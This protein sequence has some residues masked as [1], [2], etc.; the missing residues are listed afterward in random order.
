MVWTD[1]PVEFSSFLQ[2]KSKNTR[3]FVQLSP[4]NSSIFFCIFWWICPWRKIS[5]EYEIWNVEISRTFFY[6][7]W[8]MKW[9]SK[10]REFFSLF[11]KILFFQHFWFFAIFGNLRMS[12]FEKNKNYLWQRHGPGWLFEM[13]LYEKWRFHNFLFFF[14]VSFYSYS[15]Y[16]H[17]LR[18][19]SFKS[20]RFT[21]FMRPPTLCPKSG[22]LYPYSVPPKVSRIVLVTFAK[23]FLFC[24]V[25]LNSSLWCLAKV[26]RSM[27]LTF[28]ETL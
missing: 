13:L 23:L 8:V 12:V 14:P 25:F 18:G 7:L 11:M 17:C 16:I 4:A 6:V 28:G 19:C 15:P 3:S 2:I 27:R 20:P 26:T 21:R 22:P 24:L 5:K 9:W 10:T 1:F